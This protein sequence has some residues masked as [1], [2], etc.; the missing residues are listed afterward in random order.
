[1]EERFTESRDESQNL[2]SKPSTPTLQQVLDLHTSRRMKA[3]YISTNSSS[4]KP[5]AG[6]SIPSQRRWLLYWSRLLAGQGPPGMWGLSDVKS[7]LHDGP[8]SPSALRRKVRITEISLRLR[9]LS[10]IKAG[11]IRAASFLMDRGKDGRGPVSLGNSRVWASL[12]RYDDDLVDALER[13]EKSTRD[14]TNLGRRNFESSES[15]NGIFACDN[16]D[17]AKMVRRFARMGDD[18]KLPSE[19]TS[20]DEVRQLYDAIPREL[21]NDRASKFIAI[22]SVR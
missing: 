16:W 4:A 12:A 17:K 14:I 18:G 19:M 3:S 9:E 10:G 15:V 11:L 8:N 5:K 2:P 1:M 7:G 21:T 13:W 20:A 22:F 6:V